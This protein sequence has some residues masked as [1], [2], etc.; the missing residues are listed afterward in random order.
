MQ[1]L[2]LQAAGVL[3]IFVAI[4]HGAIAELQVFPKAR[5]EPQRTRTLLRAVWQLSTVAWIGIGLLLMAAPSF[6]SQAARH[7]VV[8]VAV[9]V[10]GFAAI[11]NAVATRGRHVGWFLMSCVIALALIGL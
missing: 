3:A 8:A 9:A 1:D 5:V 10:Y 2:A 11:G 7:W 6:G 4:V